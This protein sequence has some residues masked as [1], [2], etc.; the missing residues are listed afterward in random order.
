M[1]A[2]FE[3][4][5]AAL[6]T[7]HLLAGALAGA[8]PLLVAGLRLAP[9]FRDSET[10]RRVAW[11]SFVALLASLAFGVLSLWLLWTSPD[12]GYREAVDRFPAGA[13]TMLAI[14]WVFT[15][16]L[17]AAYLWLWR[18]LRGRP[19]LHGAL[20]MVAGTN[21]LYH[22]PTVMVVLAAL[23]EDPA[24][25]SGAEI[26]RPVFRRLITTPALLAKATHYWAL[27]LLTSGVAV[28]WASSSRRPTAAG[29][30]STGKGPA[31]LAARGAAVALAGLALLVLSG[32]VTLLQIGTGQQRALLGNDAPA[33]TAFAVA[34]GS[35]LGLARL[36]LSAVLGDAS[37]RRIQLAG[38]LVVVA[39]ACMTWASARVATLLL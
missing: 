15:A 31:P 12:A 19:L 33:T 22:F 23:A 10:L 9:A 13:Y 17:L 34:V 16:V 8:G 28:A 4:L 21:L 1:I 7:G 25:A 18:P 14:E 3:L 11:L 30:A 20:A 32:V 37:G 29:G 27:A 36:L 26:A 35:A 5:R 2:L 24:L 39:T 38:A 6:A